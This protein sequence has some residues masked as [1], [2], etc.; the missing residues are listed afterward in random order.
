MIGLILLVY[1][2]YCAQVLSQILIL[3]IFAGKTG[4]DKHGNTVFKAK[5]EFVQVCNLKSQYLV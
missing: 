5:T 3:Y 2:E 1:I 4:A